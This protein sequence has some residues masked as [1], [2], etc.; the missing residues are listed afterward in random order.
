MNG[1]HGQT[2]TPNQVNT[3]KK[4]RNAMHAEKQHLKKLVQSQNSELKLLKNEITGSDKVKDDL[5]YMNAHNQHLKSELKRLA[6][7][8]IVEDDLAHM[9]ADNQHMKSELK[10]LADK[11]TEDKDK[12]KDK[13]KAI[14]Y[15]QDK[16]GAVTKAPGVLSLSLIVCATVAAF[17]T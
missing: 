4:A 2:T 9:K 5:A 10:R 17:L 6:D 12:D 3:E 7:K 1:G 11:I 15:K 13:D 14:Q 8:I 16:A